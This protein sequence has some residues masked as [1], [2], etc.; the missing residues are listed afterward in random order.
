MAS[1][2]ALHF[3]IYAAGCNF[4]S[5]A[6][7][8]AAR[9][10]RVAVILGGANDADWQHRFDAITHAARLNRTVVPDS[11]VA[12]ALWESLTSE[13]RATVA[14]LEPALA[15]ALDAACLRAAEQPVDDSAC[16]C[17][18]GPRRFCAVHRDG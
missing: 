5:I 17:H 13:V 7:T 3:G 18:R 4:G 12:V 6:V 14:E 11:A 8:G 15:V 16:T 9:T 1:L 10:G 2:T